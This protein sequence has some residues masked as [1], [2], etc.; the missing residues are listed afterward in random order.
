VGRFVVCYLLVLSLAGCVPERE[1]VVPATG[2]PAQTTSTAIATFT[3]SATVPDTPATSLP[4]AP[5]VT[6]ATAQAGAEDVTAAVAEETLAATS[7]VTATSIGAGRFSDCPLATAAVE[8]ASA[9]GAWRVVYVADGQIWLREGGKEAVVLAEESGIYAV[10]LSADGELVAFAQKLD[11]DSSELWLVESS[12]QPPRRLSAEGGI[13]GLVR[14]IA[15][16]DDKRL[17]AFTQSVDSEYTGD[18]WVVAADGS[19]ARQLV[20][21]EDMMALADSEPGPGAV[22][23]IHVAWVPGTHRLTFVPYLRY[24]GDYT[25]EVD[26]PLLWVDADTGEQS[27]FLGPGEGGYVSYSPDGTKMAVARPDKLSLMS[28]ENREQPLARLDYALLW[29]LFIERPI[30]QPVWAADSTAVVLA[31]PAEEG[32]DPY[33]GQPL[34]MAIWN[35]PAAGTAPAVIGRF[36]GDPFFWSF[37]PDLKR[38][39]Y[40][41]REGG[42]VEHGLHLATVD[43][44]VDVLYDDD[45][46]EVA[47]APD[48]RH[49]VYGNSGRLYLGD[50]CGEAVP[51]ADVPEASF[52]GWLD[53]RHFLLVRG[54]PSADGSQTEWELWLDSAGGDS[55]LL[56]AM[57]EQVAYDWRLGIGD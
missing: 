25:Q 48:S 45:G 2:R 56:A 29:D 21:G 32:L 17:V 1:T 5:A 13:P 42:D 51:V 39:L 9:E 55:M 8:A 26:D 18:L 35:V 43:L 38:F 50:V 33:N 24:Q 14:F 37:S 47:W 46:Y 10:K 6:R 53:A 36:S 52:A 22:D 20:R 44:S 49:F 11:E 40:L 31:L 41:A 54:L 27:H 34:P 28:V 30:P 4:M 3:P 23:F 12:G 15:F 16:S 7:A 57:G 19:G